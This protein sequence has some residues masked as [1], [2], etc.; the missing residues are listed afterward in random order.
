MKITHESTNINLIEKCLD[1]LS[2]LA[3]SSPEEKKKEEDK[4]KDFFS[5]LW[6]AMFET[7]TRAL[8]SQFD[9]IPHLIEL[10]NKTMSIN[11]TTTTQKTT[12]TTSSGKRKPSI[13]PSNK[14]ATQSSSSSTISVEQVYYRMIQHITSILFSLSILNVNKTVIAENKAI[15]L[16][17]KLLSNN[18]KND[19]TIGNACGTLGNLARSHE[20][21]SDEIVTADGVN[22]LFSVL[23][24]I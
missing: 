17:I 16:L 11:I 22:L 12:R 14:N 21:N 18:S 15:P 6:N 13:P 2:S 20:L 7:D 8:I 5:A 10:L 4:R 23:V 3:N 19:N 24:K 9:G 1:A